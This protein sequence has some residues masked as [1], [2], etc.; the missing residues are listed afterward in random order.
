MPAN[1]VED[2]R[3]GVIYRTDDIVRSVNV[4]GT[5][6]FHVIV[7]VSRNFCNDGGHVLI[8]IRCE[9]CLDYENVIVSLHC[10]NHPEIVHVAVPVEV[11]VGD[12]VGRVVEKGLELPDS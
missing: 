3:P 8:Y 4:G 11:K 9:H 2:V 5:N 12:D 6:H 7:P 1:V 10:R